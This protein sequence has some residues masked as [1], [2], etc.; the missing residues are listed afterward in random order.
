MSTFNLILMKTKTPINLMTGC[1]LS[2]ILGAAAVGCTKAEVS[3]T[4]AEKSDTDTRIAFSTISRTAAYSLPGTDTLFEMD[5]DAV[6]AAQA[7]LLIP[8]Y[9]SGSEVNKLRNAIL[10]EALGT[11]NGLDPQRDLDNYIKATVDS[12]GYPSPELVPDTVN[13]SDADGVLMLSGTVAGMSPRLL[14]YAV[15]T[16]FYPVHAANGSTDLGYVNYDFTSGKVLRLSDIFT[17]EGLKALPAVIAGQ[18]KKTC[19][20]AEITALPSRGSYYVDYEGRIVFVYQQGEVC[21]RAA[22]AVTA[23]FYPQELSQYMTPEGRD[24]LLTSF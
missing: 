8:T 12:L 24:A 22:G 16:Y 6:F 7:S 3:G 21:Y 11:G 19:P 17:E 4:D 9:V 10:E 2:L 15:T 18:A 23:S 20:D 5:H 13:V 14:S 1:A